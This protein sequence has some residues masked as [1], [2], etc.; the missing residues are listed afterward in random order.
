MFKHPIAAFDGSEPSLRALRMGVE[1]ATLARTPLRVVIVEEGV[2]G[3]MQVELLASAD[4]AVVEAAAERDEEWRSRLLGQ[5]LTLGQAAGLSVVAEVIAGDEVTA[6][7]EAVRRHGCDLLVVGLR[8]HPGLVE[9][10]VPQTAQSL[11]ERVDCS[12]LG[13]R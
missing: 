9:R 11:T 6:I 13:V 4:A 3:A 7:V 8:H 2:S 10:L 12:V 5:A 1:L